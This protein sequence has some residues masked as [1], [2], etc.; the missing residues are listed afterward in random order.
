MLKD[1][2]GGLYICV[3]MVLAEIAVGF[4]FSYFYSF[5]AAV[6]TITV[7]AATTAVAADL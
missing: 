3:T 1:K 7:A 4:L 6:T 5:A 2:K